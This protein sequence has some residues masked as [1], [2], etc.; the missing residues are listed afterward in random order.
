MEMDHQVY[1]TPRH[2]HRHRHRRHWLMAR[3]AVERRMMTHR[4]C[5]CTCR[6]TAARP[7]PSPGGSTAFAWASA[8]SMRSHEAA[9]LHKLH[10]LNAVDPGRLKGGLVSTLDYLAP[11]LVSSVCFQMVSMCAATKRHGERAAVRSGL[12]DLSRWGPYTS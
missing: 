9:G 4:W 10:K 3:H 12:A 6:R 7:S 11:D 8:P 2:R 1:H 5:S